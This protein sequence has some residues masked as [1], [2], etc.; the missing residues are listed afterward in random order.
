MLDKDLAELYGVTTKRLNEQVKRN[1]GRFPEDFMFRL[2]QKEKDEVVANCDHL[3]K[4]KYSRNLPFAF[5]EHGAIMAA[6]VLNT[7]WAV[8]VSIYVVRAFV[9]LRLMLAANKELSRKLNQLEKRVGKHDED[10]QTLILAIRQLMK[11]DKS[12]K[13]CRIGFKN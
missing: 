10:I 3:N 9:K 2:T 6:S 7:R 13:K 5:T 8:E 12:K 4:L 1:K 11:P